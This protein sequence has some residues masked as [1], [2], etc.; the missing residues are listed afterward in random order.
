MIFKVMAMTVLL[1]LFSPMA[2]SPVLAEPLARRTTLSNGLTLIVSER[3]RLPTIHLQVLVR[4]GSVLDLPHQS[5]LANLV[6]ELLPQGSTQRDAVQISR[7]IETVG[8]SLSS[9]AEADYSALSLSI[10]RKDLPLGLSILSDILLNPGFTPREM[11][12]K[13]SELKARFKRMEE[14]PRQVARWTFAKKLFGSHPYAPPPEGSPDTLSTL[15]REDILQFFQSAY[16]AN[17]ACLVMVGQI[18]LEEGERMIEEYFKAW[19]PGPVPSVEP[20]QPPA[21]AKPVI[22]KIDRPITQ[23]NIIWGHLGIA[24]DNP[25]YYALQVMNYI[26]GGGGFVSRLVD[27]IRDNLG[28][29]Y[30]I[31]SFFD[32]RKYPGAF[33]IALETK[34]KNANQALEEIQKELK[35]FLEKGVSATELAEAKAYLTGSFP[36]RMDTN[37]KLVRLLSAMELYGLGMDFPEKYSQRINQVTAEEVLR[38][39]RTYLHPDKFLLVVVGDQKEIK[40]KDSW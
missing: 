19:Q 25:D 16:R 6:A 29:T 38:M 26:L 4:A 11:E 33:S 22:E 34:N 17:N 21:L 8:G 30:G 39:A 24:R 18:T 1:S 40:L 20:A 12:R 5:G 3:P 9:S 32:A 23:A 2:P 14:D 13:V 35:T 28:L 7:E 27:T 15:T 31:V 37:A 10:L 36:L